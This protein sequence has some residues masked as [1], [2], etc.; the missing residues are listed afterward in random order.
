M[1]AI[2]ASPADA[3]AT[4]AYWTPERLANAREMEV[5][6]PANFTPA[7]L[8]WAPTPA[9]APV[10]GPGFPGSDVTPG[11]TILFKPALRPET[12][13]KPPASMGKGLF[14]ESRVTPPDAVTSYPFRAIGKLFF[15]DPRTGVGGGCSASINGYRLIVTA[16]HCVA[17]GSTNASQR[18]WYTNFMFIP[19]YANGAAP[20]GTWA[21]SYAI[22]TNDWFNDGNVPNTHDFAF[23][24]IADQNGRTIGAKVGSLGWIT[25]S[26]SNN[27][28]TM[29]GYPDNL[30]NSTTSWLMQRNDAQ[31]AGS[32]GKNTWTYGS[33]MSHGSSGGPWVQDF[34]VA[35]VGNPTTSGRNLVAA[36]TSYV[37]ASGV[38]YQGASQFDSTF[39]SLRNAACGH[40]SGNC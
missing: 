4:L 33:S 29:L 18:Y 37:P 40:A 35:P 2:A 23:I 16:G 39:T 38:G 25:N 34:G 32:G 36:V 6:P 11:N 24:Q 22:T 27:H 17:H 13:V 30:D 8:S 20:Y 31:T 5:K 7:P 1:V 28:L 15:S 12:G 19:A 3:A 26:I 14:T 21:W 9:G 10:S